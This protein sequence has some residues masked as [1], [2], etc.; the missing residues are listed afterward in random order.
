MNA[1]LSLWNTISQR[2]A[3]VRNIE[4]I[5]LGVRRSWTPEETQLMLRVLQIFILENI[6]HEHRQKHGTLMEPLSGIRALDHKIFIK[7]HWTFNEIRSMSLEDKLLVLHDEI[8]VENLSP[9]AQSFVV[10]KN[11]SDFSII[12]EDFRSEEWN[13]GENKVFL[14]L[15]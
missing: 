14:D 5:P 1:Y 13:Y 7:T 11:I 8:K 4:N 9:E 3:S 2:V 15:L 6:L 10:G 12:F